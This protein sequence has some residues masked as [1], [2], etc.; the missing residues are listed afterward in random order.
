MVA[1][2]QPVICT[3]GS[4]FMADVRADSQT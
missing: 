2:A 1:R 3:Q 4:G